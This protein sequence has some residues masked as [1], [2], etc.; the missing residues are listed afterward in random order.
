M[1]KVTD[2]GHDHYC[3]LTSLTT[4]SPPRGTPTNIRIYFLFL[5]TRIIDYVLP[6]IL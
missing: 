2:A 3:R 5:E 4:D 1:L 6:L